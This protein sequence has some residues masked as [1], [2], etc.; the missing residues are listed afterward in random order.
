M[1]SSLRLLALGACACVSFPALAGP[2]Y[3]T[4]DPE[5]TETGHWEIYMFAAG[6]RA[7]HLVEGSG[8]LDLNYGP[9]KRVQLTATLPL[10]FTNEGGSHVG[11]GK[12]EAGVKYQFL[13]SERAQT[14]VAIFPRAILPTAGKR[15]GSGRVAVLLPVWGQKDFGRWSLFGGGGY[16]IN[17]G[18]GQRD[19]W[20]EG[21]AV[22]AS[23]AD[24]LSM[25]VE[26]SHFGPD[27]RDARAETRLG[28]G[29]IVHLA[30][31]YSLLFSGGPTFVAGAQ[32][33][34]AHGYV[35][36]GLNF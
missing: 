14:S 7:P 29:G 5:P 8:G 11:A 12:I 19:F 25:G 35:A 4:D 27:A 9:V 20:T 1:T 24:G 36:L 33:A 23:V 10:A 22:T 17:P 13:K 30:G 15:F 21:L 26:A 32:H 16:M 2:P 31:P 34:Q 28:L 3:D 6:S 18:A